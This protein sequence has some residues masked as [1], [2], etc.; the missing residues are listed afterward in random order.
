VIKY[1]LFLLLNLCFSVSSTPFTA[2]DNAGM[3]GIYACDK[4]D[5]Q[6]SLSFADMGSPSSQGNDIW[7][8]SDP[9]TN[10]EYALMGLTTGTAFVDISDPQNP[11]YL[12]KLASAVVGSNIWRD[13]KTYN[14]HA[15]IVSEAS[16]HGMQI[17]D[18][19]QLRNITSPPVTFSATANYTQFG[20]AHNIAINESS[21]FAY[22]AGT[23]N[24]GV[25]LHMINIQNP[26]SPTF[27]GCFS[28]DGHTHDAQCVNYQGPDTDYASKEICFNANENTLT[29]VDVSVK[30][31]PVQ[32]SKTSYP[33]V[34]L[35]HQGWNTEDHK[36]YLLSDEL[37]ES[38]LGHNTKT[39]IW[40]LSD[41]DAPVLTGFYLG[42][43][44]AIDHNLY[45]KGSYAYMSNYTSGLSIVDITDISNANL[46]EVASFDTYPA[47][48]AANFNG[49]W[50]NYPYFDSGNIIVSDINS[51]LF[52]LKPTICLKTALECALIQDVIFK[53]SFEN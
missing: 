27:A 45:T 20:Q 22:A 13:I 18:L 4:I 31:A 7:G 19:T 49:A 48:N 33:D 41:L 17:F 15:F 21:G 14:N 8:W 23:N 5:L 10:K 35:V 16:N 52:I 46:N 39:Y 37:D 50:S 12:G 43:T 29:I 53:S 44:A 38:S 26:L 42:P 9:I 24:C 34:G 40:D 51:G 28:A 32:I 2:C 1:F 11:V 3:A 6:S 47:N 36:Y 25:G 30:A